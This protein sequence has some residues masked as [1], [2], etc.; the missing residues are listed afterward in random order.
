MLFGLYHPDEGEILINGEVVHLRNPGDAIERGV[1]MV[2]QHFQLVPVFTV[3]ENIMLG[4]ESHNGPFLTPSRAAERIRELSRQFGLAV[5]PDATVEDLAGR[6]PAARRDPQGAVPPGRHPHPRRAD[7][8]ADADGDRRAARGHARPGGRRGGDHLHHPQAARGDGRVRHDQR[9]ARR[10][11]RRHHHA[12]GDRSG[13]PRQHDGRAQ[14]RAA[15]GEG[16][17]PRRRRR[18]RRA[19][20][21]GRRRPRPARR[22][23]PRSRGARPARSSASPVSRATASASSSRRCAG[24]DR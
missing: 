19:Q 20:P 18:A 17:C 10:Q 9:A 11:G 2:H 5:D 16:R 7:G 4:S 21:G 22:R 6:H 24:C 8:R 13:R 1:G 14:R 15:G 3:A 23:R 12:A